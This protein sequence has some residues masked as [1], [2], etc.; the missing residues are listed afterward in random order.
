MSKKSSSQSGGVSYGDNASCNITITGGVGGD[1]VAGNKTT[2]VYEAP[3]PTVPALQ[4][5]P[6]P[7]A[8]FT[9]REAEIEELSAALEDTSLFIF[10]QIESPHAERVRNQL[11]EWESQ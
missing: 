6:P 3:T 7:P 2:N 10:D 11:G 9:G 5:L 4:Q 1:V 8:G